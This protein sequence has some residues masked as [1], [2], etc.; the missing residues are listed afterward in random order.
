MKKFLYLFI[1]LCPLVTF[2]FPTNFSGIVDLVVSV[3]EIAIP[4]VGSLAILA[5]VW[6]LAVF[7][8]NSGDAKKHQDGKEFMIWSVVTLF[9]MA[10]LFGIISYAKVQAGFGGGIFIPFLPTGCDGIGDANCVGP[11]SRGI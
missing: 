11:G 4:I 10:T 8:L 1:S 5:F 6:G 9:V 3:I 7:I 2:A